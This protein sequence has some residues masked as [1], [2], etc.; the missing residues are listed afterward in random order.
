MGFVGFWDVFEGGDFDLGR[1][2]WGRAVHLQQ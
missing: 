1:A 2:K